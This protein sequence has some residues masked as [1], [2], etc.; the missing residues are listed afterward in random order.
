MAL[1]LRSPFQ[2]LFQLHDDMNRLFG[3]VSPTPRR[4]EA[5]QG[6]TP[7]VDIFEDENGI[8]LQM[9]V[10]GVD[11]KDLDVQVDSGMLTIKGERRLEREERRENYHR[12]ERF[13]G[14]F[15]RS[16]V[17]PDYAD[18]ERV[19]ATYK[20]GVLELFIPKKAEMKPRQIKVA[21]Q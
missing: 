1:A 12:V 2:D 5:P 17:L 4:E 18:A 8:H 20:Q 16:F 10:P 3:A 19:E 13:Y 21:V 15:T 14:P 7:Q 6:A 11:Q 9:D